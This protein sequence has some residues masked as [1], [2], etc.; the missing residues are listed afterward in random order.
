MIAISYDATDFE[1]P[2]SKA[3]R[4]ELELSA[5]VLKR[6]PNN[7][8]EFTMVASSDPKLKGVPNSIIR[9]KSRQTAMAP[10]QFYEILKK[11]KLIKP[12]K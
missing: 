7:E 1:Y 2:K 3:V 9:A 10:V 8:T 12:R 4:G 11:D 5:S 6:L